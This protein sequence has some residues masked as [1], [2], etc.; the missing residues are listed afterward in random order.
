MVRF[1]PFK[2]SSTIPLG[3]VG[4][5]LCLLV[6]IGLG[7]TLGLRG[8]VKPI[9]I[10]IVGSSNLPATNYGESVSGTTLGYSE[11]FSNWVMHLDPSVAGAQLVHNS[12]LLQVQGSFVPTSISASARL[13]KNVNIDIASFP[14]FESQLDISTMF[15]GKDLRLTIEP[16]QATRTSESTC[17]AKRCLRPDIKLLG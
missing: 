15:G 10:A 12:T 16:V 11:N 3:R 7:L 14:I 5:S 13:I 4:L 8:A 1:I 2:I 17:N 9:T 6:L